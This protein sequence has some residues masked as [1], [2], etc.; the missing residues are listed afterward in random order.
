MKNIRF[1][2][3]ATVFCFFAT[4]ATAQ[5]TPQK[6]GHINSAAFLAS[7]PEMVV[8]DSALSKYRREVSAIG[9]EQAKKFSEK[10]E[11]YMAD[12]QAG[13]L[14]P[15]QAKSIEENLVKEQEELK[16]VAAAIEE[17]TTAK[18]KELLEPIFE[19]VNEAVKAVAK[20]NGF[21]LIIDTSTGAMLFAMPSQDI[22]ELVK[23]KL[24]K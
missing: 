5:N 16:G 21:E 15:N 6:I 17:R 2:V 14:A 7:L 1:V 8:A 24:G 3:L 18:R 4:L 12:S 22:T 13:L 10:Y 19:K 23:K 9:E 20:E 11:K